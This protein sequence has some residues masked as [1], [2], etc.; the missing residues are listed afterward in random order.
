[1]WISKLPDSPLGRRVVSDLNRYG[2]EVDVVWAAS[3]RQGTYYLEIA[4]DPRGTDVVYDR[5]DAA[6]TTATADELPVETICQ[7]EL[8]LTSG[9]TPALSPTLGE[10]WA[11]CSNSH[12]TRA[13]VPRST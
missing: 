11:S 7:A 8:F 3:G 10:R 5:A 6:I 1:M 13:F 2:L 4:G 12:E 9:I